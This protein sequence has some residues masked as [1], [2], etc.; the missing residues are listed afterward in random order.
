MSYETRFVEA[1]SAEEL[2][3]LVQQAE[4]EGWQF[5]SAQVTMVW[6]SG[7]P[8]RPGEPAGHARKCMLAALHRPVAFGEQA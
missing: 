1:G 8:Q 6:V 4:R 3:S 5:V 2:T 7:E